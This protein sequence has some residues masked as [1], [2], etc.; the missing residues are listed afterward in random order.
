MAVNLAFVVLLDV[1]VIGLERNGTRMTLPLLV[2]GLVG[3]LAPSGTAEVPAGVVPTRR[4]WPRPTRRAG[5]A[6]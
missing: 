1:T 2:L 5:V 3:A 4:W 6:G